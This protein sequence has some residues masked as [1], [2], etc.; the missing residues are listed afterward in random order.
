VWI[1]REAECPAPVS[2][3]ADMLATRTVQTGF[4]PVNGLRMYYEIH[5]AATEHVR[6]LM[7]HG[8]IGTIDMFGP[9]LPSLAETRQVI[10]P[11][12]QAH[13]HTADIDRPLSYLQMA[14]DT[15]GLLRYLE[16]GQVD[17]FGF[18][19]GA[20]IAAQLA[21]LPGTSLIELVTRTEWLQ[22]MIT[23]FLDAPMPERS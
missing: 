14:D 20:G 16:I 5:G 13:G 7:L 1:G 19:M 9:L 2:E 6:L 18:S 10:A 4:A 8:S 21:I 11:E 3:G 17:V 22:S 23:A 15:A 12:Q